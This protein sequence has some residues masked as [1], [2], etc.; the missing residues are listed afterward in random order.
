MKTMTLTRWGWRPQTYTIIYYEEERVEVRVKLFITY[1]EIRD[2]VIAKGVG[3]TYET[4]N[5]TSPTI[6]R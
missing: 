2:R 6:L 3:I 4:I 1:G 5:Y